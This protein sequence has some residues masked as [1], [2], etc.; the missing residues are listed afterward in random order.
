MFIMLLNFYTTCGGVE[1]FSYFKCTYFFSKNIFLL[2]VFNTNK[3]SKLKLKKFLPDPYF[4][5]Q[6]VPQISLQPGKI[7]LKRGDSQLFSVAW[8]SS[9]VPC[10]VS[11]AGKGPHQLPAPFSDRNWKINRQNQVVLRLPSCFQSQNT[12]LSYPQQGAASLHSSPSWVTIINY[13][14]DK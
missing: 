9:A 11:W 10:L 13:H 14:G 8:A 3:I 12:A 4:L 1:S 2:Q 6:P 7:R 5:E